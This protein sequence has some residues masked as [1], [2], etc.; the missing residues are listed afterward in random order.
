MKTELSVLILLMHIMTLVSCQGQGEIRLTGWSDG[1]GGRLEVYLNGKWGTVS[2]QTDPHD[3]DLRL[4]FGKTVCYQINHYNGDDSSIFTGTV[5][6]LNNYLQNTPGKALIKPN[7]SLYQVLQDL[8]CTNKKGQNPRHILRCS[9]KISQGHTDEDDLAVL[10]PQ[11]ASNY[12]NPHPGQF[13]LFEYLHD[14]YK[15]DPSQGVVQVYVDRSWVPISIVT[16]FKGIDTLCTELGYTHI[17]QINFY[18]DN[19]YRDIYVNLPSMSCHK[20]DICLLQ[21]FNKSDA[22]KLLN[23]SLRIEVGFP[24]TVSITCEFNIR[25][26]NTISPYIGDDCKAFSQETRISATVITVLEFLSP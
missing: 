11:N 12:D 25:W 13:R 6:S 18:S 9:Y 22:H 2:R 14:Q 10:C 24:H 19:V 17:S 15:F 16:T 1:S 21:C 3:N 4:G 23:N 20:S 5:T 7:A 8:N 26:K